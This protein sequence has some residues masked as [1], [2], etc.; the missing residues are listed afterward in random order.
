[1]REREELGGEEDKE[2]SREG[3]QGR[4]SRHQ[5]PR[6]VVPVSNRFGEAGMLPALG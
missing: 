5:Y 3:F 4:S 1:M 2:A 6:K